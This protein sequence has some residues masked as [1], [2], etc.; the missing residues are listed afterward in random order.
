MRCPGFP[1]DNYA[2]Y[3]LDLLQGPERDEIDAHLQ[4]GCETCRAEIGQSRGLWYSVGTATTEAT[5]PR[6]LRGRIVGSVAGKRSGWRFWPVLAGAGLV[7]VAFVA[8][9]LIERLRPGLPLEYSP[10]YTAAVP[11]AVMAPPLA[12]APVPRPEVVVRETEKVVADPAQAAAIATLSQDVE[13]E[14]ERARQLE[15]ELTQQRTTM[16][17]GKD[18]AAAGGGQEAELRR[19]LTAVNARASELDRQVRQYRILV[20]TQQR[21]LDQ[22]VKIAGMVGDPSLRV[23]RLR[24]TERDQAVE[25]HAALTGNSQMVFYAAHLPALPAGRTYQL[26]LV[27]S[28]GAAVASA[29]TFR[30]D[31]SNRAVVQ[32]Q[33]PALLSGVTALAVTDEPAG[34]SALPTGHKW[35]I[36][37]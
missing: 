9:V 10:V 8:G 19:Q 22:T 26:W 36:G 11:E 14:R 4:A 1:D 16:A 27:R 13:R 18:A 32:V 30:P 7:A 2:F 33:D 31:A 24:A 17:A 3:A 29:G 20:E 12:R 6:G 34:G 15:A 21:R 37:T 23:L 35:L 28:S 25:G 5:P